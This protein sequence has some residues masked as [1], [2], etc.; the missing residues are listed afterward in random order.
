MKNY[1]KLEKLVI[2]KLRSELP[3]HLTYHAIEHTLDVLAVCNQYIERL[4][5]K[6]DEAYLLRI[7]AV[8][9]DMGFLQ[10]Y[11]DHEEVSA[12]MAEDLM[13]SMGIG[14][15][16]IEVVKG[17]VLSTK[18]PQT[19]QNSL[20][21]ILCDA[22]LDYLGRDDYPEISTRLYEEFIAYKIISDADEWRN[23]QINFLKDHAFHTS[24]AKLNRE[25]KKQFW[26]NKIIDGSN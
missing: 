26:L 3:V 9:H 25:P 10:T 15:D 5:I 17:L 16:D 20:Q 7:G 13:S 12:I 1:R 8:V 14:R 18:I 6:E 11:T 19:P 22:D 4:G 21:E 23:L 2:E 24:Y